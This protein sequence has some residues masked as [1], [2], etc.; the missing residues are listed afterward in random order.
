MKLNIAH[1]FLPKTNS[2]RA[3]IVMDHF[4]ID[5]EQGRHVIAEGL[6]LPLEHRQ[7][8]L[9]TGASGTGK[10]S[11]MRAAADGL[12]SVECPVSSVQCEGT[13]HATLDTQHSTHGTLV[14]NIDHLDL[15]ERILIDALPQPI[16]ESMP[17]LSSCG[18]G[19]AHLMLR[20][21]AELS[22]G[23]RY[24]FRLALALS[25][26]PDWILA[27][28]FTATLDRTL[29]KV[30]AYGIR[31]IADRTGTGFLLA[32]THEDIAED[33]DPDL[34]VQCR[35][36][37]ELSVFRRNDESASCARKKKRSPLPQSSG[38]ARRPS[39]IG[40]TSLGGI[41]GAITSG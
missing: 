37:G 41:I 27:D 32:T 11:L 1:D 26:Q 10:S 21:P 23:Q 2:T 16:D 36:D 22:D 15:G 13:N 8:V 38:S 12:Q 34:H 3:S 33:L 18:L 5:F 6:E 4:G 30:V 25:Q 29:A 24:R 40:R 28:E 17:L 20:T 19:E 35:L 7:V 9:F 39:A 14:I 31:R